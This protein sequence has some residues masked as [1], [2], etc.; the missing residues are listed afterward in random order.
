MTCGVGVMERRVECMA[1]NGWSSDLC[2]KHLKPDAQKKCYVNDCKTFTTCKE[3]QV[4]NSSAKDGD[5]YLN[6]KGKIIKIYCAGMH[7]E[8][9]KE[10]ISLVKGEED[11]FSE[12][13][14]FRLQNPYECPFNGS[15]RQD[16]E[17]KNDYL[18]AGHTVFSKIR[19]DL[20]SMQIK[21][22]DFLFAQTVFGNAIPFATAGDCYSAAR[23]PQGQFSINLAGTGMKI[24][25]TAKWL[26]QGSYAFVIIHRSQDGTKVFGRCGGFCGKCIPH[27][28]T[29]LPIQVI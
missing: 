6:I 12:V 26:A 15:R 27:M 11:N 21:T 20:I 14:G 3:I 4:K 8:N 19:I 25:S 2:L 24:A 7:L 13:Y 10:Y 16:C 17:C 23:C 5:Y 18:A 29:G 28:T 9:P 1:E 22:T